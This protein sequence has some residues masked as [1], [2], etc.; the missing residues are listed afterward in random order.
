MPMPSARHLTLIAVG[1]VAGAAAYPGWRSGAPT[2][3]S[4]GCTNQ[5]TPCL[6]NT[7]GTCLPRTDPTYNVTSGQCRAG[8]TDCCCTSGCCC[9]QDLPCM[10]LNDFKCMP[11]VDPIGAYCK[12]DPAKGYDSQCQCSPPKTELPKF[13]LSACFFR[14]ARTDSSFAARRNVV[15]PAADPN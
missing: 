9:L 15:A 5:Q 1:L 7:D 14:S 2:C 10:Q 13:H 8:T 11:K 12:Y 3:A 6:D 4:S